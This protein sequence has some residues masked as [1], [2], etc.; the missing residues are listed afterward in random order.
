[1][2]KTIYLVTSN[3]SKYF[4]IKK[5][6]SKYNIS[7]KRTNF[8]IPEIK[9]ELLEEVITDKTIKAFNK[10]KKPVITDDTGIFF[11]DYNNFPG[12]HSRFVYMGLGFKG[13]F[14]LIKNN[15]KAY[16]KTYVGYMDKNLKQPKL[17]SGVCKGHLITKLKGNIRPK[18]PYDAIFI[19]DGS[20]RTFSEMGVE[21][22]QKYDHRSRAIKKFADWY[23]TK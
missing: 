12:T 16:F 3:S 6:L 8:D 9:S 4:E 21:N 15:N 18:M 23:N 14:K 11:T 10:I 17:F 1:M 19:P 13:M 2:S 5:T 20:S 7:L 22:K